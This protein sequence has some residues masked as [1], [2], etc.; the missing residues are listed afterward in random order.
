YDFHYTLGNDEGFWT[1]NM[2][3]NPQGNC[4][5]VAQSFL[6]LLWGL[7]VE[8]RHL[9]MHRV[10]IDGVQRL[11]GGQEFDLVKIVTT[12]L[13]LIDKSKVND[14]HAHL[15]GGSSWTRSFRVNRVTGNLEALAAHPR[16]PFRFHMFCKVANLGL[17]MPYFDPL[18]GLRYKTGGKDY[19]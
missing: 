10:D 6:G 2:V 13:D 19:F 9:F 17:D 5:T 14:S 4:Q 15:L 12:P 8:P 3:N 7:S 16:D 18:N 11:G 1:P